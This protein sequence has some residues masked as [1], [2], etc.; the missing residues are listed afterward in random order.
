MY[1]DLAKLREEEAQLI[2][3]VG[4][5]PEVKRLAAVRAAIAGLEQYAEA[6]RQPT[7]ARVIST[8]PESEFAKLSLPKAAV[9]H[10]EKIGIPQT[11]R[12]IWDALSA[13]GVTLK[14]RKPD[15]HV[16]SALKKHIN[17][18][19]RLQFVDGK[20][21]IRPIDLV[22]GG[23]ADGDLEKHRQ[24]TRNGIAHFKAR[25]GATWGRKPSITADQIEK[26]RELLDTGRYSVS[27]A[28]KE[29]GMSNAYFYMHKHAILAWTKGDPWPPMGGLVNEVRSRKVATVEGAGGQLRLVVGGDD[30]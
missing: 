18:N 4:A 28:S 19:N 8:P 16:H 23:I 11:P 10:L 25:T 5:L 3:I 14:A 27:R 1:V 30:D 22:K 13:G 15:H 21:S 24:L 9:K 20:W 7:G 2:P 29:A 12:E 6:T 26:F 17:K